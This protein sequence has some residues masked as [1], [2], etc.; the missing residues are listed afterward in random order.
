MCMNVRKILITGVNGFVGYHVVKAFK[1]SNF[2]TVGVAYNS[3]PNTGI[4]NSVDEYVSCDL[5]NEWDTSRIDFTGVIAIIHLAGLSAVGQSFEQP[6]R[7]I[8]D[9]A[10]MTYNLLDA[11]QK[12]GFQGRVVVVS[13][14]ALYDANQQLPLNEISKSLENSPYAVGKL[15]V[16]HVSNYF[17]L[18]GLDAVVVR[19][20]NHIGPGQGEGF[21]LPDLYAQLRQAHTNDN[22]IFVGNLTTKRDY[23]DVRDIAHA[24]KLIALTSNLSGSLY[25]ICSGRSVS[26]NEILRLLQTK[27]GLENITVVV[28]ETKIRPTDIADI[29]GDASKLTA[30]TGWRP[31]ISLEET[32]AAFLDEVK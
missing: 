28:D 3:A 10:L 17:R 24:Y 1:A 16:E 13:T 8:A 23:T 7:Y 22:K 4:A 5:L 21:L 11:A 19:P 29:Y 6:H 20:F 26:G 27:L 9:N 31:D 18:R 25:N 2:I 12:A 32:I 15:G 14:G 30:E